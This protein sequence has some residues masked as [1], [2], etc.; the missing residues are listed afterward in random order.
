M[1]YLACDKDGTEWI[2]SAE[3]YRDE[4]AWTIPMWE[5]TAQFIE[6][7]E[8]SIAKLIDRELTWEDEPVMIE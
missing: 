8:G 1:A 4:I 3:P 2:Y 7:P 6:L 5:E